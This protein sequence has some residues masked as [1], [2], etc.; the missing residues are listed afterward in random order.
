MIFSTAGERFASA[1][2]AARR[3]GERGVQGFEEAVASSRRRASRAARPS[4]E[5]GELRDDL[6]A[7][8]GSRLLA[9]RRLGATC[10]EQRMPG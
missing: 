5:R 9:Q 1:G 8:A 10:S 3:R 7:A 2:T 6:A 4:V